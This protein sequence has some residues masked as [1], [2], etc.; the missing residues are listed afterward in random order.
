MKNK[1]LKQFLK[2]FFS[3]PPAGGMRGFFFSSLP[4]TDLVEPLEV[5]L[6]KARLFPQPE[7][8]HGTELPVCQAPF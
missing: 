5:K 6:T 1:T 2:Q 7:L 4:Y 3:A 8:S